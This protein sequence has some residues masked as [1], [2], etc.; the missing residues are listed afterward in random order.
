MKKDIQNKKESE[1]IVLDEES[2]KDEK[3]KPTANILGAVFFIL[4][5]VFFAV[6]GFCVFGGA[7]DGNTKCNV[8]Y[9]DS[10]ESVD[11][12]QSQAS[13]DWSLSNINSYDKFYGVFFN[14]TWKPTYAECVANKSLFFYEGV[15]NEFCVRINSLRTDIIDGYWTRF[16][17]FYPFVLSVD[18]AQELGIVI[19][20]DVYAIQSD[21]S[22]DMSE[23]TIIGG[24]LLIAE[25]DDD[26]SA[27]LNSDLASTV[28]FTDS[29]SYSMFDFTNV[30]TTQIG[31]TY[32]DWVLSDSTNINDSFVDFF[33]DFLYLSFPSIGS[34]GISQADYDK[35]VSERDTAITERD[36]AISEYNDYKSLLESQFSYV[37]EVYTNPTTSTMR[38][39]VYI[40]KDTVFGVF[41]VN[42]NKAITD[43]IDVNG[44]LIL[45]VKGLN[46]SSA[47]TGV[48]QQLFAL[49]GYHDFVSICNIAHLTP[50]DSTITPKGMICSYDI[51]NKRLTVWRNVV[52]FADLDMQT[53]YEAFGESYEDYGTSVTQAD[54]KATTDG[55]I[56][57]LESP[58]NFLKTVFNF[59]IFGINLSAVVF[60]V[61]SIVIVA[62][63]IK[64]VV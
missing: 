11:S 46:D 30:G 5:A 6:L 51:K 22:L 32:G 60:F 18:Y 12:L 24:T 52:T 59:E 55:I 40:N 56:S 3:K 7:F 8:A 61:V 63:V 1:N 39:R 57:V 53:T 44:N 19:N 34:S 2:Q 27:I 14:R 47:T 4:L 45:P 23:E 20:S 58:V 15:E 43:I 26:M 37:P 49:Q 9:A 54:R 42:A 35:V 36:N 50:K 17:T 21:I 31:S 29:F 33:G 38:D 62:F 41:V 28:H 13:S 25:N 16:F 48:W 10:T 64:K